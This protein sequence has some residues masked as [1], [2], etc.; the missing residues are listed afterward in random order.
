MRS[1]VNVKKKLC[2]KCNLEKLWI[3]FSSSPHNVDG[4]N[5]S[6]KECKKKDIHKK[7]KDK[8]P[9]RVFKFKYGKNS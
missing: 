4:L 7:P 6:C 2:K 3:E 1:H 8:N 9:W 5:G